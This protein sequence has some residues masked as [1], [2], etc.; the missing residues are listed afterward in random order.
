MK[1]TGD[2]IKS[3]L[4]TRRGV[5]KYDKLDWKLDRSIQFPLLTFYTDAGLGINYNILMTKQGFR[6]DPFKS[7]H[8]ISLS[9]FWRNKAFIGDYKGIWT[10]LIGHDVDFQLDAVI[11]GPAFMQFF[12]GLTNEYI[13]Y[14]ELFSDNSEAEL[15]N[16]H[17]VSGTHVS[18]NP[19]AVWDLKEGRSISVSPTYQHLNISD[20]EG[21]TSRFIYSDQAARRSSDFDQKNYVGLNARGSIQ[22]VNNPILPTRGYALSSGVDYRYNINDSEFSNATLHAKLASYIPFNP[23]KSIVLA[24][25]IG[26]EYTVGDYEFFHARYLANSTRL[27]GY[28]FQRFAGD[29]IIYHATDLRIRITEGSGKF[30]TGFGL[31]GSFD[32]GR[33]FNANEINN[34]WHTSTGGG[35]FLSPLDILGLK[36][37]YHVGQDDKQLFIG[38]ALSF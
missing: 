13:N 19:A 10:D 30:R 3:K 21:E 27:R 37:G 24:M 29:G 9:Y 7:N 33:A 20:T 16:F 17:I 1:L 25:N 31:Y 11:R 2:G 23:S 22:R 34:K 35:I 32:Y 36:I 8:A 14:Q 4:S 28:R 26:A 12:Y 15:P 6:K 5:N 18:V 38:S